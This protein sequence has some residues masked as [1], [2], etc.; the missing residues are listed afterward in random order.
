MFP[1]SCL[2]HDVN[3]A[4]AMSCISVS[5]STFWRNGCK[6]LGRLTWYPVG[7]SPELGITEVLGVFD[8][9]TGTWGTLRSSC[10]PLKRSPT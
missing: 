7:W 6:L 8:R 3:A 1:K 5:R 2:V 10:V 4:L 9:R